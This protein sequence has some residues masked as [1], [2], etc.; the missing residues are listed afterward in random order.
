MA[1]YDQIPGR[2]NLSFRRGDTVSTELDFSVDVTG[3]SFDAAIVSAVTGG[4]IE[5]FTTQT[6]NASQGKVVLSLTSQETAALQHGTYVWS[7]SWTEAT[8]LVRTVL[9]GFVE[10]V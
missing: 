6:T 4:E 5:E 7:M 1:S 2:F 8:G 3:Y 10:V 9:S